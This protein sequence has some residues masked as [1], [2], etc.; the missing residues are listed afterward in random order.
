MPPGFVIGT[1]ACRAFLA[2]GRLPDGL[3]VE[4]AAVAE[5]EAATGRPPAVSVRSGGR[6]SMPGM[7]TTIL[8]LPARQVEP[9]VVEVLSSWDTPRPRPTV[10]SM[11]SR[12]TS[13]RP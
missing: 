9:A 6:E 8:N 2:D 13:A 12:T 5:L 11:A 3:D 7:M 4:L 10:S 1:V